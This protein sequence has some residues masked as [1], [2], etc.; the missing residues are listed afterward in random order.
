VHIDIQ[1]NEMANRPAKE[2]TEESEDASIEVPIEDFT[3]EFKL[4]TWNMTQDVI[5]K[6]TQ[7]KNKVYFENYYDREKKKP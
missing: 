3:R 1:G 6:K 5:C 2:V 7:F 4:E